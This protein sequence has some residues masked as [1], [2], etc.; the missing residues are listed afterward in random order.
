[1][2]HG[3]EG[4]EPVIVD[5][6]NPASPPPTRR[7]CAAA[8]LRPQPTGQ[9]YLKVPFARCGDG[10]A[11]HVSSVADPRQGPFR[12]LDC[13]EVLT[14]RQPRNKRQHF[15]HRPDSQ[16]TG[17]TAL[18][19]YAKEIL[20]TSKTLTLPSLI[21]H[22][23]GIEEMVF[24][25][26][27]YQFDEV[28]PEHK[29][30]TFQPDA[31]VRINGNELAVEFL[32]SHAVGD[33]KR[34]KVQGRDISMVEIDLSGLK[35]GIMDT[36]E[37]DAAILH[38]SPRSWI[39]HRKA[40]AA[41]R[42]LD[43]AVAKKRS[44]RGERLKGHILRA[45]RGKPPAGW[46]DAATAAVRRTGLEALI[47][48]QTDGGHWF[49]VSDRLWQ[50]QALYTYVIKPSETYSPGG[51][52][53]EIKGEFPNERDLSSRLPRWMIRT[54]LSNYPLKRLN[55]AGFSSES[56]GSPHS[57]VWGYFATL[58]SMGRAVFWSREDQK[59]F[60]EK[61]LQHL[62]HRRLELRGIVMQLLRDA[63][64]EEHKAAYPSWANSYRI[65]GVTAAQLVETGGDAYQL[66]AS[67]LSKLQSMVS[68][69]L[70]KVVDDLC[71]LP[72]EAIRQRNIDLIAVADAKK[73]A[74][75]EKAKAERIDW[76]RSQ[77]REILQDEAPAWLEQRVKDTDISLLDFAGESDEG[78]R[79]FQNR[80][81]QDGKARRR[82]IT[83]ERDLAE[84]RSRLEAA[85]KAS[86]S[87]E[88]LADLF[89]RSGHPRL[90]GA[91][92]MEYCRSQRDLSLIVSLLPKNR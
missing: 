80:L 36:A 89:L 34:T 18:H 57:S 4:V 35:P 50:A 8:I 77:A 65:D 79:H 60:V 67:R 78:M 58:S 71:G 25:A 45:R 87:S 1:M 12:C 3:R 22:D 76:I 52:D 10:V 9:A 82:R 26:G 86:F 62:L 20:A 68:C 14:L 49:T 88:A 47:D 24:V 75:L 28:L 16:C 81:D 59:F 42:K 31:L 66:L 5:R 39:H 38:R 74:A 54:D 85:A 44:E 33:E 15:A 90:G 17:E 56:Y 53:L 11:R 84:V 23:E 30:D 51:R 46:I 92:P 21:L 29:V 32:V 63:E 13:E 7:P 6:T 48:V 37:L 2:S 73:A 19:R 83:E 70:P 40:A 41:K 91:R 69:Y 72:L 64:V 27:I 55:E 43:A 61:D